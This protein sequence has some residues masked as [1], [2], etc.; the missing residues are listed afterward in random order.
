MH[1][2]QIS[3][4]VIIRRQYKNTTKYLGKNFEEILKLLLGNKLNQSF[5]PTI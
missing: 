1:F 2:Y 4:K 3:L 5:K